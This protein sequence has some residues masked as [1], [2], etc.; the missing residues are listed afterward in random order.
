MPAN[1]P[2]QYFAAEKNF[3]EA[4]D[5]QEKIA[6][7]EEMIAIMPKHKG[8]DHLKAELRARIAKLSQEAGRHAGGTRASMVVEREG[9]GQVAVVGLPNS[10]KSQLV[11]K[12]TNA[13][14]L[15]ADYPLTT[16]S[17]TPG[18]MPYDGIQIQLIDT[19][20]LAPQTIQWWLPPLL[21][22]AD[23]L[24]I[25]TDLSQ[26]PVC[27]VESIR[28]QLEKMRV[29]LGADLSNL[30][31][32]SSLWHKRSV[33]A[34]NNC[35]LD[36]GG[37]NFQTMRA[38]YRQHFPVLA[39]SALSGKGLEELKAQIFKA[40]DIIRI[41]TKAP[42]QKADLQ[43]P[44]VLPRGSTLA[45]AAASVHKDL[46]NHLKFARLWG[47]GKHEGMMVRRDYVLADGDVIELHG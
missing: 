38:A 29:L 14:P 27:Q 44:F 9:A 37:T 20:P 19:P 15:V 16:H 41:F 10:G 18:M 42:G 25:T 22:R 1:L 8:T 46:A 47:S 36:E 2:P 23:A 45:D 35:E 21:R 33:L 6:A 24:L 30:D 32:E 13:I 40:L 26:E 12:L 5:P 43:E 3:R 39:I 4:R 11:A 17:A 28:Q 34:G 31:T 7:L